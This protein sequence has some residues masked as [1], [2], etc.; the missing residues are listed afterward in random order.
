MDLQKL[1][2]GL[3][4]KIRLGAQV[5]RI[6]KNSTGG[7]QVYTKGEAGQFT[8]FVSSGVVLAINDRVGRPRVFSCE[9][10]NTSRIKIVP[11]IADASTGVNWK[12]KRV[13]IYGH[14]AFAV[15]A[16]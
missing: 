15:E 1:A 13:V 12:G 4:N 10:I 9:G 3:G 6:C 11:G 5:M 8:C 14:G 16:V 2:R 7:Y